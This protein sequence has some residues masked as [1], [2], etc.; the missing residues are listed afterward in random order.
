MLY[1]TLCARCQAE[2]NLGL[3]ASHG[4]AIQGGAL[5]QIG[6]VVFMAWLL[7]WLSAKKHVAL[8]ATDLKSM[9]M[10]KRE[11]S[12]LSITLA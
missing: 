5:Q 12:S 11:Y 7:S 3:I 9:C 4:G 2:L 6:G 10:W 1:F 8:Q